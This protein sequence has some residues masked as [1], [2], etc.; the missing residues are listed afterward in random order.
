M[1]IS[2]PFFEPNKG[3]FVN[4]D[5]CLFNLHIL[6]LGNSHHCGECSIKDCSSH[7]NSDCK[8]RTKDLIKDHIK[9]KDNKKN[10]LYKFEDIMNKGN[11]NNFREIFWKSIS[12]YN[13]LQIALPKSN[14]SP[15]P[16]YDDYSEKSFWDVLE[17][18]H[19]DCMIVWG[20]SFYNYLPGNFKD[21]RWVH[22]DSFTA[23][24]ESIS[25]NAIKLKNKH[26]VKVLPIHHPAYYGRYKKNPAYW[27]EQIYK[28]L[29]NC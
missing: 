7:L 18:L 23:N 1:C 22:L 9:G 29:Y 5:K 8:Q 11:K 15:A 3:V 28:F 21:G 24:G 13:Y 6:V 12:F 4:T 26:M 14:M 10:A 20:K 27:R 17:H 25:V 19:P 16:Y 2:Y